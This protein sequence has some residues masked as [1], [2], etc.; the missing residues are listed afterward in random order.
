[1]GD[2]NESTN[3]TPPAAGTPPVVTPPAAPP[4]R[5]PAITEIPPERLKERI[6]REARGQLKEIL[7]MSVED[8]KKILAANAAAAAKNGKRQDRAQ[9]REERDID[10][11]QRAAEILREQVDKKKRAIKRT[12]E[13]A[14]MDRLEHQMVRAA[15]A[16]GIDDEHVDFALELL[17]KHQLAQ[18][19]G[20]DASATFDARAFFVGLRPKYGYLFAS[21]APAAQPA[22]ID[23]PATT[24]P[25]QTSAPG[26][27]GT[28]PG[29]P[30]PRPE[31]VNADKMTDAQF[32]AHRRSQYGVT[33]L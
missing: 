23:A 12:K 15:L 22:P 16:A 11:A 29:E 26:G 27:Q 13:R 18:P 8:A 24:S 32:R 1:M 21:P 5:S 4:P 19:A 9:R 33:T 20:A 7:G 3:G 25:P 30:R 2:E 31:P 14:E 28:S 17:R 10:R 6:A